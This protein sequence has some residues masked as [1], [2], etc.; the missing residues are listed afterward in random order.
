MLTLYDIDKEKLLRNIQKDL[1]KKLPLD[2]DDWDR[3]V[4]VVL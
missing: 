4:D 3:D 1:N 2:I